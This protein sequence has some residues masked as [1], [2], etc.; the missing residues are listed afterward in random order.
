M[1]LLLH[2]MVV[3]AL[4]TMHHFGISLVSLEPDCIIKKR[5]WVGVRVWTTQLVSGKER[6]S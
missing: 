5:A 4:M 6:N 3:D 1:Q 2:H